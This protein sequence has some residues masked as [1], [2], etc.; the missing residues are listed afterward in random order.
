MTIA[1]KGLEEQKPSRLQA[2]ASMALTTKVL[3]KRDGCVRTDGCYYNIE[4]SGCMHAESLTD[5]W[6]LC[7]LCSQIEKLIQQ[8]LTYQHSCSSISS[9]CSCAGLCLESSRQGYCCGYGIGQSAGKT[10]PYLVL[11][12]FC[13]REPSASFAGCCSLLTA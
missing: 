2:A 9:C 1:N 5:D 6:K 12:D 8:N 13:C 11:V 4:P 7:W 10:S 3:G